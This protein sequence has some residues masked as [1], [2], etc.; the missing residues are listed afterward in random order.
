MKYSE[1]EKV[2]SPARMNRYLFACHGDT[3]KRYVLI[4]QLFRWMNIEEGKL[5]YGLDH[6]DNTL[7]KIDNLE[8][9]FLTS[10]KI[11]RSGCARYQEI[12]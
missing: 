12:F 1:F 7:D 4:L 2:M 8:L 3:R 10:E 5:L 9:Q 6:V 11:V